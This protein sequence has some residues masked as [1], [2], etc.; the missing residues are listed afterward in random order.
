MSAQSKRPTS[1]VHH[2]ALLDAS[3]DVPAGSGKSAATSIATATHRNGDDLQQASDLMLHAVELVLKAG[4]SE[5]RRLVTMAERMVDR[6][7][8]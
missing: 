5:A 7:K 8:A 6:I 3:R 1:D 2:Q 4:P